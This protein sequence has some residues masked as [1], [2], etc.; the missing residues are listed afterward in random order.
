M[1]FIK[2]V[3]LLIVALSASC[4][5]TNVS[6]VS[7]K[8]EASSFSS[9]EEASSNEQVS[10]SSNTTSSVA[11]SSSVSSSS[12]IS[13]SSLISSSAISSSSS[14]GS[15]SIDTVR[16]ADF[17]FKEAGYYEPVKSSDGFK[18]ERKEIWP[19]AIKDN[20]EFI[21]Y[22][23]LDIALNSLFEEVSKERNEG[24]ITY[25]CPDNLTFIVNKNNDTVTA[26]NY[27]EINL[28]SKAYD[29]KMGLIDEGTTRGYTKNNDHVYEGE[30]NVVF[31]LANYGFRIYEYDNEFYMPFVII[32]CITFN[33]AKWSSV[34]FNGT[35][36]YLLDFISG[37]M[38]LYYGGSEYESSF[39]SGNYST[40]KARSNAS[41]REYNYNALMFQLDY[42]YGF[43]DKMFVPFN[44]YLTTN[45]PDT[46]ANLKSSNETTYLKEIEYLMEVIIGDGHT[47]VGDS[48]SACSRATFYIETGETSQRVTT[49]HNNY[50][51]C[52]QK[53]N[54]AIGTPPNVRFYGS[55]AIITFDKFSH[56]GVEFTK[57]NILGYKYSDSFASVYDAFIKIKE[58]SYIENVIF[59]M[60]VN[61]GGDTNAAI[62]ILGFMQKNVDITMY[63]P[64]TKL[65]GYLS[66]SVD[67]NLDGVYNEDDYYSDE[68]NFF[69]LTS[70][71]SFSCANFF[72]H[73]CKE[74]GAAKIIGERS[75]GG[76]CP[77]YYTATP[78]GKTYRISAGSM[79]F[80]YKNNPVRDN[81]DGVEVDYRIT[82]R[83]DFYNDSYL[84]TFVNDI[85]NQQ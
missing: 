11:S 16:E 63:S 44:S 33:F 51:D 17:S 29:T 54:N 42:T 7:S 69:I 80:G 62:P 68:Y 64:L 23:T 48:V 46:V 50:Y 61:S 41:F 8:E 76:A 56:A 73:V 15:S 39:H 32:N 79:R 13:S 78:D 1:K 85:N 19:Y 28:F 60:T 53:R 26:I 57:D 67:T 18:R 49:L 38:S 71:Y 84:N 5:K 59:D 6:S 81:D 20:N 27:D 55:T 52:L 65:K 4:T 12:V 66:Y 47:N 82:N 9:K 34:N 37:A 45:Y 14:S 72:P 83:S 70:N 36:F 22:M 74:N 24:T 25:H 40:L 75:G 30:E 43:R 31:E 2:I 10:S 58:R 77:V 21:P 35:A 3:P